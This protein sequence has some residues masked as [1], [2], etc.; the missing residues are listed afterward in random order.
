MILS[1]ILAILL[2]VLFSGCE[3]MT[4]GVA[5]ANSSLLISFANDSLR[6]GKSTLESTLAAGY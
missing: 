6:K 5:T 3:I 1:R 4:V 2:L